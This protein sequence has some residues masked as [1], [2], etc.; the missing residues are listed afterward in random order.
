MRIGVTEMLEKENKV[1]IAKVSWLSK[2]DLGKAYELI[3][4]YVTKASKA[5]QLLN[6][7]YFY[8][9]SESAYTGEFRPQGP[10]RCYN[11]YEL[12]YKAYS[13]SKPLVCRRCAEPG[14]C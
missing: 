12:G 7:Q 4:V 14:H 9:A 5:R 13:C 6:R 11:C 10:T 3:V 1:K 8:I 2:K